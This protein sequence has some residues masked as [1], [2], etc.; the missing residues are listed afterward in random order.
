MRVKLNFQDISYKFSD[1][2]ITQ[3][4]I[5]FSFDNENNINNN[6]NDLLNRTRLMSDLAIS[7]LPKRDSTQ[8]LAK[9][10]KLFIYIVK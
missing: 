2:M 3:S 1:K 4:N 6:N 7:T 9:P 8:H 5:Y 10:R